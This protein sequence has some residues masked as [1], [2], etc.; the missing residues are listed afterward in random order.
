MSRVASAVALAAIALLGSGAQAADP[1]FT[2]Q[3]LS[4]Q[5]PPTNEWIVTLRAGG[6]VLPR[7]EGSDRYGVFP[8]GGLNIQRVGAPWRFSAPDDGFGFALLD[9]GGFRIGPVARY[10]T[11]RYLSDDRRLY[12]LDKI[13]WSVEPGVFVE[14]YPVDNLRARMEIRH[15]INGHDGFVGNAA[16]DLIHRFDRFTLS[17]GPRLALGDSNYMDTMFGVSAR[18]AA[19]NGRVIP[20]KANGGVKSLGASAALS[21]AWSEEWTTTVHGGYDRLVGD[22]ADSPITRAFG[23]RDQFS[24]GL[25]AA[26]S[27]KTRW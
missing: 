1:F 23:S 25:S 16:I 3:P 21:Y 9:A 15:G 22:A 4:P 17:G 20:F 2:T 24:F 6:K 13:D 14:Y 27:F 5:A 10:S 8:S 19:V 18:E 11:G 26:Y 7:F 12:G